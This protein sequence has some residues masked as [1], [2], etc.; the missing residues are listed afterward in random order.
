MVVMDK[1]IQCG[2]LL[3]IV[4]VVGNFPNLGMVQTFF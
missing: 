1:G 3:E 4:V 2:L